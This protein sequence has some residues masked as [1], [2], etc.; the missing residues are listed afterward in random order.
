MNT[1]Y[2]EA[3]DNTYISQ[4]MKELPAN[5]ILNKVAVG[6]GATTVALT[7]GHKTVLCVPFVS[8]ILNKLEWC[9]RNNVSAIGVYADGA[10]GE[11]IFEF[12]G[13]VILVTW[14]SLHKVVEWIN[15][16]EW[17]IVI[18]E[19]HKLI[20]SGAFRGEAILNVLDNFMK[21]KAYTFVTA[22]P[23]PDE[24]QLPQLK[25]IQK[26]KIHWNNLTPVTINYIPLEKDLHKTVAVVALS[27]LQG[28]R[29]GN[30]HIFINS[31]KSIISIVKVL[32]KTGYDI[33]SNTRIICANQQRNIDLLAAKLPG[34]KREENTTTAKKINFYTSTS[35]EGSD[36][37]D[38]EG[39]SYVVTD[40]SLDYT[41]IN[42]LTTLPQI[43][44]RIRD[45]RFKNQLT[46]I[47]TPNV[48][49]SYTTEEEFRKAVLKALEERKEVVEVFAKAGKIT[50]QTLIKG[51]EEDIYL[52]EYKGELRLNETALYNEMFNFRTIHNTYY[53]VK[54]P[55]AQTHNHNGIT[56]NYAPSTAPEF[57]GLNKLDLK[58]KPD[59][60]TLCEE[61]IELRESP[62]SIGKDSIEMEYPV[63]KQAYEELGI[64]KMKAL[65]F[66][67]K[68]IEVEL[69]KQNKFRSEDWKVVQILNY[70][71]GQWLTVSE[72]KEDL[73]KAYQT[74]GIQA[75]PKGTDI[76]K[77]YEIK[78]HNRKTNDGTTVTGYKIVSH[79]IKQYFNKQ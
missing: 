51:S 42:I 45:S 39:V 74:L 25:E 17:L 79:K 67:R 23:V 14:D 44:G 28:K 63:I 31:V 2:I 69:I 55:T 30:A 53:I 4:F 29:I 71:V 32:A 5:A 33:K 13:N 41:K 22:T 54:D 18:D 58:E 76:L 8:L 16:S 62:F 19:C 60:K 57:S 73:K 10:K 78:K 75:L 7:S 43:A 34:Y 9:N 77:F 66:R 47:Y 52:I 15:P 6:A 27:H 72:L 20:D 49:Y 11:D 35:F 56:Y 50:K 70:K 12:R 68:D 38:T 36:L 1:T 26:Y 24:Y 59:F 64:E 61:Y 37:F 3:G 40:G 65:K 21:F 48:Y 46:L